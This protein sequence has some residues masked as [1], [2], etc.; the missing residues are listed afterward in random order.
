M[1]VYMLSK[2]AIKRVD[3]QFSKEVNAIKLILAFLRYRL[4]FYF[5]RSI[6]IGSV[7]I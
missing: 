4:D 3:G 2:S 6:F 1:D 5:H 7:I